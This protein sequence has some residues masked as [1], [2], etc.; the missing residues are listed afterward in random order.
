MTAVRT[1][2][3]HM[4]FLIT[5]C[6]AAFLASPLWGFPGPPSTLDQLWEEA[7]LVVYARVAS[8]KDMNHRQELILSAHEILKGD[9]E[10]R[11]EITVVIRWGGGCI[12][13]MPLPEKIDVLAFLIYDKDENA[14]VPWTPWG[15]IE[16]DEQGF[17]Q[18][19]R[20]LKQL[21]EILKLSESDR[22]RKLL[23]WYVACAAQPAT[24]G[25]GT[26]G[27]NYRQQRSNWRSD[28]LRPEQWEQLVTALTSE[29]PPR[30]EAWSL[31]SVLTSYPSRAVDEYLLE[32]LKRSHEP[33]WM[34][35][36]RAAVDYLPMRLGI[37]LTPATQAKFEEW[38]D[39][40]GRIIEI[41]IEDEVEQE[42]LAREKER[43]AILWGAFSADVYQE[44]KRAM[45]RI[46]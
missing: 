21:P 10:Q 40:R 37:C 44:C 38:D 36:T 45:D 24:R 12:S 7:H 18:Y 43:L 8:A 16:V 1:E 19:S 11:K 22:K 33:G 31:A 17:Q 2:A 5:A 28:F 42:L 30:A 15:C 39:L 13:P 4:V 26:L 14:F 46:E 6:L 3:H 34:D 32:C 9:G 29:R 25:Q 35:F 20:V 41:E 23:D 27:I